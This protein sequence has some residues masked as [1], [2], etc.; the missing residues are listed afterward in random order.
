MSPTTRDR[1]LAVASEL[2]SDKGYEATSLREI[3]ERL[4]FTKAALYYHFQSKDQILSA[5]LEPAQNLIG[6]LLTRLDGAEDIDGWAETL[7]WLI[8]QLPEHFSLLQLIE[9]NRT[10]LDHLDPH[11]AIIGDHQAMHRRVE[12]A[13]RSIAADLRQQV[14]MIAAL[15]AV[16][17]FDD[18]APRL[19]ADTSVDELVAELT[20]AVDDL[21]DRPR[22]RSR[23]RPARPAATGA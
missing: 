23:R 1:I 12:G 16:T 10:A 17:G 20:A 4:G 15:G 19:L 13:V 3:S 8:V 11:D 5:L 22:P 18:W 2:F 6:E 7:H 14:R 21:L 9:R